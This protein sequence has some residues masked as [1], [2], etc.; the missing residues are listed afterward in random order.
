[1]AAKLKRLVGCIACCILTAL[2]A[3]AQA[4]QAQRQARTQAPGHV[5]SPDLPLVRNASFHSAALNREMRYRIYLPHLYSATAQRYPVL[6][7]LHGLYGN[8]ENWDTL[9]GLAS[10]AAGMNWIIVMPDA[11]DSWYTNSVTKA[12][13]KFEDY[14]AKD[15]IAE[16]DAKYRTI[17]DGQARA[18]AGLSMGGY[19]ALKF[20]LRN[21]QSFAFAGS[22]SGAL[23]AARDL[24]T[25]V[26]EFA[27]KLVEVFGAP[28][29]AARAQN[30]IFVLLQK[31][32]PANLPYLYLAC[33]TEDRFLSV[34]R[35]F[36]ADLFRRQAR[37]EYHETSGN[38]DWSYW[39]REIKAMLKVM[40]SRVSPQGR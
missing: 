16:I 6:Y 40:G 2:V 24:D 21:P 1:M 13:D 4:A 36:A 3:P 25:R 10:Y 17:H 33:G 19:G 9:T 14:I 30:D 23:D 34:N 20:A 37:Y 7:L 15:L 11:D 32:D 38:H 39:D 8:Y 22:L 26:P 27:A 29:N 18:I 31:D 35:E 28:S 12:E 5:P